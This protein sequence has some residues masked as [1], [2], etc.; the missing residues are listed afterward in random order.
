MAFKKCV[1]D[2]WFCSGSLVERFKKCD[3][4]KIKVKKSKRMGF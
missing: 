3:F 1:G 2:V 4:C